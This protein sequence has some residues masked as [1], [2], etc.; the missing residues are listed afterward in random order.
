M[1]N[2]T[3]KYIVITIITSVLFICIIFLFIS[4]ISFLLIYKRRTQNLSNRE[5]LNYCLCIAYLILCAFNVFVILS[6]L[7]KNNTIQT[8]GIYLLVSVNGDNMGI[9]LFYICLFEFALKRKQDDKT[10]LI[11]IRNLSYVII[12]PL[13][14]YFNSIHPIL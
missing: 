8:I 14:W 13:F 10:T 2:I 1:L 9:F 12:F 6:Q 4:I 3:D 5:K 7:S 11:F